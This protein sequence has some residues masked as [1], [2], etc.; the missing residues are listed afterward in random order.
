[1]VVLQEDYLKMVRRFDMAK[2]IEIIKTLSDIPNLNYI[3]YIWQSDKSEPIINNKHFD[4]DLLKKYHEK[5]N[6][7]IVEG[8]LYSESDKISISIRHIDSGYIISE[9]NLSEVERSKTME[10]SDQKYLYVNKN[11]NSRVLFKQVW[12]EQND[13]NTIDFKVLR[14]LIKAFVGFE[15]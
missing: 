7:F 9:V 10:I 1:M 3:G 4:L 14:P 13:D 15:K 2:E 11:D 6:P 8:N 5:Q 12:S